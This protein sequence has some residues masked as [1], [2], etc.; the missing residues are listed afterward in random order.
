MPT[1]HTT[2][3]AGVVT[4]CD[5][6]IRI[7]AD[8]SSNAGLLATPVRE[9]MTTEVVTI[10][11]DASIEP[12]AHVIAVHHAHR[13]RVLHRAQPAGIRRFGHLGQAVHAHGTSDTDAILGLTAG[14]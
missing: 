5:V 7:C 3:L 12:A 14:P 1:V 11:A 13:L 8:S 2:S 4:D 9:V 6:V 10:D